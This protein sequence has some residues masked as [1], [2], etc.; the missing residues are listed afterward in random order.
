MDKKGGDNDV[1]YPDI[2]F[3]VD[4]FEEV[5]CTHPLTCTCR[6]VYVYN[7]HNRATEGNLSLHYLRPNMCTYVTT[8]RGTMEHYLVCTY[9]GYGFCSDIQLTEPGET[10][11]VQLMAVNKV[12][13]ASHPCTHYCLPLHTMYTYM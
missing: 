13:S 8:L 10:V 2:M 4:G 9:S 11:A 3:C 5:Q 7:L 6:C 12:Q 1:I